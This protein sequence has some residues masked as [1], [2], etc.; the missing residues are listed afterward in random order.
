MT[1]STGHPDSMLHLHVAVGMIL[2][3]SIGYKICEEIAPKCVI[4]LI[5][6]C[7]FAL[8]VSYLVYF[9]VIVI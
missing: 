4:S 8:I 6:V 2:W 5:F 7:M 1:W 9:L 3:N